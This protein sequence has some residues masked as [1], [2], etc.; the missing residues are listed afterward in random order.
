MVACG[1]GNLGI[2]GVTTGQDTSI[3]SQTF[4]SLTKRWQFLVITSCS[5]VCCAVESWKRCSVFC[6]LIL[7]SFS[8]LA[9]QNQSV[10]RC[11]MKNFR[12][13]GSWWIP[14]TPLESKDQPVGLYKRLPHAN[15]WL[16]KLLHLL[17]TQIRLMMTWCIF[18]LV[19]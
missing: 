3:R 8:H 5:A 4:S 7:P 12:E 17:L 10:R 19:T 11:S 1:L 16:S 14:N 15:D 13:A 18:F 9:S 2:R 6:T